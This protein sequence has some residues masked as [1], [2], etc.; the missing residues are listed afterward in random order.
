MPAGARRR[1]SRN[2]AGAWSRNNT[3]APIT[4]VQK[5][6]EIQPKSTPKSTSRACSAWVWPPSGRIR[7]I[8]CVPMPAPSSTNPSSIRRRAAPAGRRRRRAPAGHRPRN[9]A[10]RHRRR[11]G[12]PAQGSTRIE[13]R[14][15]GGWGVP[16]AADRDRRSWLVG[17]RRQDVGPRFR[18]RLAGAC[19]RKAR[20][21][22]GLLASS[23]LKRSVMRQAPLTELRNRLRSRSVAFE[24]SVMFASSFGSVA[25]RPQRRAVEIDHELEIA[26][27]LLDI[28]PAA[29]RLRDPAEV[30]RRRTLHQPVQPIRQLDRL[31]GRRRSARGPSRRRC[32]RWS[33]RASG[34]APARRVRRPRRRSARPRLGRGRS[35]P[36]DP[37]SSSAPGRAAA[38]R[39]RAGCRART[40]S[41]AGAAG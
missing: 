30:G 40:R 5:P 28:A 25:E 3:Q 24:S 4:P 36:R 14:A 29:T 26:V 13:P 6:A 41:P 37:R 2:R 10:R 7:I 8:A 27:G 31:A 20:S 19:A 9:D 34:S 15:S 18:D 32:C 21:S 12:W 23:R 16:A 1:R 33:R 17:L 38:A 39:S 35:A 22:T 11:S